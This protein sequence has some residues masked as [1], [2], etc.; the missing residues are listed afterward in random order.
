ME[1][2]AGPILEIGLILLAAVGIGW[3]FRRIGLPAVVGYLLIGVAV[4]PFTPG[5][6]ADRQQIQLFADVGVIL[7][8][9][10]V[11]IEV[12]LR[13]IRRERRALFIAAPLQVLLTT[14]LAGMAAWVFG[15]AP[16][17]ALVLG[18]CVALSSSV[19]IVNITRSRRR[20]T[21]RATEDALLGWSV[22]QDVTGVA[23][24]A[25][26][27]AAVGSNGLPPETTLLGLLLFGSVSLAAARILP[28]G[29]ARISDQ[30]DLFLILSVASGLTI[31][32]L[33]SV[34]FH[35][36][37]GLAAFVGGLAVSESP[38]TVQ[39][40]GRLLPFRD[41]L[42]VLFFVALGMLLDPTELVVGIPWLA[43]FVL[44]IVVAKIAVA[45]L[46]ARYLVRHARPLQVAVGL[47]QIGEFSFVLATAIAAAGTIPISVYTALVAAA[48]VSI[49]ASA[50]GVRLVPVEPRGREKPAA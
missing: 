13:R 39:A 41:L 9:F 47:G 8:L 20:T 35:V 24:A 27:L 25:V 45:W 22:L 37:L 42:A 5:F 46:L 19:V 31:A 40:R 34:V 26:L 17:S 10:E 1:A 28:L 3:L 12:D 23:M 38:M 14:I 7:L 33:G 30:P 48:A 15:I 50:V 49:A 32:G 16:A 44:L 18:L 2:T 43:A 4:S 21:D 6:V 36:P 29:L 11:G